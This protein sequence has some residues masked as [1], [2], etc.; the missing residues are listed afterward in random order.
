L[1]IPIFHALDGAG[2]G[3][4]SAE[5]TSTSTST[6]G[7]GDPGGQGEAGSQQSQGASEAP[8]ATQPAEAAPATQ[9]ADEDPYKA[10][11]LSQLSKETREKHK[12]R[13]DGLKEKR[14]GEVLDEYF[15]NSETLDKRAIVFPGKDAKPEEIET[16]LKRMDIPGKPE[17]YRLDHKLMPGDEKGELTREMAARFGKLGLTRKQG[18]GV[19]SEV[20]ALVKTGQ[21]LQAAQRKAEAESFDERLSRDEGGEEQAKATREWFKRYLVSLGDKEL[22]NSIKDSGLL[23]NTRFARSMADYHRVAMEELPV[24]HGGRTGKAGGGNGA[25]QYNQD[26]YDKYGGKR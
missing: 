3:A 1:I 10:T 11:W 23:Y 6:S 4:A 26:F 21:E 18:A 20:A 9:P 17:D 24:V 14:I 25:L 13:L 5:S 19:F 22:V 7:R 2:A 8:P 15:T 16:F 12:E